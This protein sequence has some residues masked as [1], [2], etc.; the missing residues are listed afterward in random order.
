LNVRVIIGRRHA[1]WGLTATL[2]ALVALVAA[3]SAFAKETRAKGCAEEVIQDWYGDGRVDKIYPLHCYRDALASLGPDLRDYS[4]AA[5]AINRALEAARVGK[6]DPGGGR[7]FKLPSG[8]KAIGLRNTSE[9]VTQVAVGTPSAAPSSN[10]AGPSS[11]PIPLLV[12]AGLAG[13][14]MLAGGAGYLA[15]RL[16]GRNGGEPPAST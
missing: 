13:V 4:N 1:L 8:V 14:L 2:V 6:G 5:D 9:D 12:L 11:V 10:T 15:R 7:L 3:P 16:Q